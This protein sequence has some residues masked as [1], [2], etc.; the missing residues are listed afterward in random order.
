VNLV[1]VYQVVCENS[2]EEISSRG[3]PT[4]WSNSNA[5]LRSNEMWPPDKNDQNTKTMVSYAIL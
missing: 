2:Q 3:E 5:E 4:V 1:L